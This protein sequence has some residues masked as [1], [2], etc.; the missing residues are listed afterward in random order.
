VGDVLNGRPY[1]L[2]L[3]PANKDRKAGKIQIHERL[4][5]RDRERPGVVL[6][7]N[8]HNLIREISTIPLKDK[9]PEDVDTNADDHAYDSLRYMAMALPRRPSVHDLLYHAKRDAS[10]QFE[11]ADKIIGY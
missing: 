4:S 3:R 6:C 10:V 2:K 5:T 7:D 11:P 8:C 9:D 1:S